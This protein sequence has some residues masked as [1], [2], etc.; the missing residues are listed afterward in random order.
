MKKNHKITVLL[1]AALT[2]FLCP[3]SALTSYYT[4]FSETDLTTANGSWALDTDNALLNYF[5]PTNSGTVVGTTTVNVSGAVGDN[6]I[7]STWFTVNAIQGSSAAL[8]TG[9]GAFGSTNNFAITDGQTYYLADWGVGGSST[10]TLR[11][12]AQPTGKTGFSASNGNAGLPT[13]GETYELRLTAVYVEEALQMTLA[14][15]NAS[16]DQVGTAATATDTAPL[17]GAFFGLRNRTAHASHLLNY[18]YRT[19]SV[20]ANAPPLPPPFKIQFTNLSPAPN[21]TFQSGVGD[22]QFTV[23]TDAPNV[24]EAEDIELFLNGVAV[25]P[26]QLIIT[27]ESPSFDVSYSGLVPDTFYTAKT[28]AS[29]NERLRT[30][31]WKFNTLGGT[32]VE[33][34]GDIPLNLSNNDALQGVL[35]VS[36]FAGSLPEGGSVVRLTDATSAKTPTANVILSPDQLVTITWD[37]TGIPVESAESL[38]ALTRI[39]L[40]LAGFDYHRASYDGEFETSLDGENFTPVPG[41]RFDSRLTYTGNPIGGVPGSQNGTGTSRYN[42]VS[43]HFAPNNSGFRY[44]RFI[45]HGY[46]LGENPQ[47]FRQPRFVEIDAFVN[48]VPT[49]PTVPILNIARDGDQVILTWEDAE[50]QLETASEVTGLWSTMEGA[51]SPYSVEPILNPEQFFRLRRND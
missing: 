24:I 34:V 10:G 49:G 9:I 14:V 38:P 8:T 21:A 47:T 29:D 45:S 44:L 2:L 32:G 6:L 13:N 35:G 19:F 4:D 23:S 42:L 1:A 25:P 36:S 20:G 50:A 7:V 28:R 11:I 15:F 27:G 41:S 46:D 37:L 18:D 17:A 5:Q 16:G 43:Y 12:L 48:F 3:V 39:D 40:W 22:L 51:T 31:M 26:E 30:R 33:T